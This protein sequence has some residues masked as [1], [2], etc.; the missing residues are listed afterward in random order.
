[1]VGYAVDGMGPT[2]FRSGQ[3]GTI[4]EAL[5]FRAKHGDFLALWNSIPKYREIPQ[6][7]DGQSHHLAFGNHLPRLIVG[8]MYSV[9]DQSGVMVDATLEDA[10][11]LPSEQAVYGIYRTETGQRMVCRGALTEDEA[12][13][14]AE[15]PDTFFGVIKKQTPLTDPMEFYDFFFSSYGNSTKEVLLNL[16]G[17]RLDIESLRALPQGELAEIYCE[18]LVYGV[19][20]RTA[21]TPQGLK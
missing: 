21:Q 3:S 8:Q 14:Y 2:D 11:V 15:Q 6:T 13:A 4:R 5:R 18:S 10:V 12:K 16:M 1:M 19:L 7:F 20:E 9:P 17:N